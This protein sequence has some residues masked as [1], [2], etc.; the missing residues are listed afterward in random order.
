MSK[1]D[2]QCTNWTANSRAPSNASQFSDCVSSFSLHSPFVSFQCFAC[3][4]FF[5]T[6]LFFVSMCV[7][8][9]NI[10]SLRCAPNTKCQ[11][12]CILCV[13]FCM[14]SIVF[15]FRFFSCS[16]HTRIVY[17]FFL[18]G[19]VYAFHDF[20][21]FG[22]TV[23][24]LFTYTQYPFVWCV[25]LMYSNLP[26]SVHFCYLFFVQRPFSNTWIWSND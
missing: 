6:E 22:L 24:Q 13:E 4:F 25:L 7:N 15:L 26:F 8:F 23:N 12:Q 18:D 5:R 14:S 9:S 19:I 11:C 20:M 10:P 1:Y 2:L 16:L 3:V 21:G 17:H